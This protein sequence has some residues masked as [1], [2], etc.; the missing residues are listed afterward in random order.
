MV[1]DAKASTN[2]AGS[3]EVPHQ[4][5]NDWKSEKRRWRTNLQTSGEDK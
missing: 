2:V 1:L 4:S 5:V 3:H